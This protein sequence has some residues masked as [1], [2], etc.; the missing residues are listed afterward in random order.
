MESKRPILSICI[1]TYNR[2]TILY[3]V[4]SNYS[5]NPEFDDSVELVISDN[6][7]TDD[8]ESMC[9]QFSEKH[10]NIKYHRNQE[11]IRDEN[12]PLALSLAQGEYLKL[13]NDW[14]YATEESL[15]YIK[16]KIKEHLTDRI[17]VFFTSDSVFTKYKAEEIEC[18]GLD[19]YVKVVSTYVTSNNLF[20]SWREQWANVTEKRK[21]SPLLL[22]QED[23][24]FQIVSQ[25]NGC[26][27]CD[28]KVF[29]RVK[30][31]LGKR[32]GYN[33]FQVHLDNYYKI[34][35]PYIEKG[36]ISSETLNEDKH[37]LLEHFKFEFCLALFYNY[38][39]YWKFNTDGTWQ[40]LCKYYKGEP[41]FA[42][43]LFR[44]PFYYVSTI[45]KSIGRKILKIL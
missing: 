15:K 36:F 38:S 25:H 33:W 28:K 44:L 7:S 10:P 13:C 20:G 37:N 23:W 45:I 5:N 18:Y 4:L 29:V 27:I 21:C 16:D 6:A 17:P 14:V 3:E 19:D 11:N 2:C 39:S 1:P 24:T 31:T 42:Y 9:K 35:Q 8:T 43:F 40:L 34:M 22:Q 41:Y 30:E 26:I 12:F 32:S